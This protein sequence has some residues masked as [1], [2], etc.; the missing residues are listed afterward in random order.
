MLEFSIA[1]LFAKQIIT[2]PLLLNT[3]LW[4][5][6]LTNDKMPFGSCEVYNK[7]PTTAQFSSPR[8]GTEGTI[9]K[10][11]CFSNSDFLLEQTQYLIFI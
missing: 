4:T 7:R 5:E 8:D 3:G 6:G 1:I 2:K 10:G 9:L 11:I